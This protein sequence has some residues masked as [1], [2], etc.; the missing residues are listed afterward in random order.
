VADIAAQIAKLKNERLELCQSLL[1]DD[2]QE[3]D[4]KQQRFAVFQAENDERVLEIEAKIRDLRAKQQAGE[5]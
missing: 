2:V 5:D 3:L 4:P 1:P